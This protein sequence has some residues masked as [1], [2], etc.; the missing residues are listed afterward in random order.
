[1]TAPEGMT[2]V[3]LQISA[4]T[5]TLT[6]LD[7]RQA[8]ET[9]DIRDRIGALTTLLNRLKAAVADHDD[10]LAAVRAL[11]EQV[12]ALAAQLTGDTDGYQPADSPRLW[13]PGD[14]ERDAAVTRL[15][16]WVDHVYRPGHGHLAAGLAD[17][18]DQH[19]LC[20]YILDWL[21]ELW[22]VLYLRPERTARTLA[23]QAEWH[24][25]LLPAAASHLAQETRRC[26]H[27]VARQRAAGWT[28]ERP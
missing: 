11:D 16:S 2:A 1:M 3:L 15:R 12:R 8:G 5:K 6:E 9:R 20:L 7:Q 28:G 25:R 13:E 18:W 19:P 22:S 17:C 14:A 21:S 4:I 27:L 23:S 24:T 10:A 26:G